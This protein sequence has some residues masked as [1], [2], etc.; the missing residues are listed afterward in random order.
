MRGPPALHNDF[1]DRQRRGR[2][3]CLQLGMNL[4]VPPGPGKDLIADFLDPAHPGAQDAR[5][6]TVRVLKGLDGV[7][8]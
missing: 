6:T 8:N 3:G 1:L 5:D 2:P 7:R 4:T